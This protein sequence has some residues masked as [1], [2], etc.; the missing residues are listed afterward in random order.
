M[1]SNVARSQRSAIANQVQNLRRDFC[2]PIDE[3]TF[4]AIC[5]DYDLRNQKAL[6]NCLK[7]LDVIRV[8]AVE[9]DTTAFDAS[10]TGGFAARDPEL[11]GDSNSSQNGTASASQEIEY[12][13][14]AE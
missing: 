11:S 5:S 8:A 3:P 6:A 14:R 7:D 2:P 13:D 9:A 12:H 4:Y 1:E 10:G